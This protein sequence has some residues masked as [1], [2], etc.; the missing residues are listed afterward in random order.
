MKKN[1]IL[2]SSI[3]L[4]ILIKTYGKS[5]KFDKA[6]SIFEQMIKSNMMINDVTY[7]C[8]LDACS[9]SGNMKIAI[10]IYNSLETSPANLNSIVFTTIIKG[11]IKIQA[12]E[13]AIEFFNEIKHHQ[14]LP[15]MIITFNCALDV[16]AR[17]GDVKNTIELF[18]SID[19]IFQADLISYSTLIKGLTQTTN[20]QIALEYIKKMI[21]SGIQIDVSVINLFL[22]SCA[23]RTDCKLGIKGY[24]YSMMKNVKPNEIT[25]GIMVK[26]F[27]FSRELHRAF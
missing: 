11:F 19:K 10:K 18:T 13:E 3:T 17:K 8:I 14:D 23:N 20:K 27:G 12:Y 15:G 5:G 22:D 6:F 7:G 9:K 1:Q 24:E 2:Q 25:F 16:Y 26:I 4:G 21:C